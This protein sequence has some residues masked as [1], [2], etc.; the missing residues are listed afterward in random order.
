MEDDFEL[1]PEETDRGP[2]EQ[3]RDT[4]RT[5]FKNL[6]PY[7]DHKYSHKFEDLIDDNVT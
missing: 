7:S 4:L 5:R 3:R 6:K 2:N 1:F